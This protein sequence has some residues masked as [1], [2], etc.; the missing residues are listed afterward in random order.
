MTDSPSPY[1]VHSVVLGIFFVSVAVVG[2]V[3]L[4]LLE[5]RDRR[6]EHALQRTIIEHERLT[7]SIHPSHHRPCTRG[8]SVFDDDQTNQPTQGE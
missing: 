8:R 7:C 3:W 1:C 2:A 6:D 5:L 4:L